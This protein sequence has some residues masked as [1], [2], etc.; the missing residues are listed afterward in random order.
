MVVFYVGKETSGKCNHPLF[1][2]IQ[3]NNQTVR[4]KSNICVLF[5]F[6]SFHCC[7][8]R[9][10]RCVTSVCPSPLYQ[11]RK[12]RDR[13]PQPDSDKNKTQKAEQSYN[14]YSLGQDWENRTLELRHTHTHQTTLTRPRVTPAD[15]PDLIM[16]QT[17]N[18]IIEPEKPWKRENSKSVK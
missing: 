17:R 16:F 8:W 5:Y 3:S 10:I 11:G 12:G 7:C 15:R 6:L 4:I 9:A 1:I 18:K 14:Q 2:L 13:L